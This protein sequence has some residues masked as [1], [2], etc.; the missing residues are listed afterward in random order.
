MNSATCWEAPYWW[1]PFSEYRDWALTITS[2]RSKDIPRQLPV[3][4]FWQPLNVV[5]ILIVDILYAYIDPRIK[6]KYVEVLDAKTT[7]CNLIKL[8]KDRKKQSRAAEIW[9]RLRRSKLAMVGFV[10]IVTVVLLAAFASVICDYEADAI[11]QN[12]DARFLGP[13]PCTHLFGTDDYGRDI[14]AR[15]LSS[16]PGCPPDR[17]YCD[18]RQW[19]V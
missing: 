12:Y 11:T 3:S 17:G 8:R 6:A 1:N 7:T 18:P 16:G 14:F 5:I 2:I 19:P 15:V 13:L 4:C 10:N 9:K